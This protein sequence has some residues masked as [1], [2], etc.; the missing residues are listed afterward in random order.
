[1]LSFS[2]CALVG[3][4]TMQQ[5]E[6]DAVPR[7]LAELTPGDRISVRTAQMWDDVTVVAVDAAT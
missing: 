5:V 4:T 1:M 2:I 7:A 6:R 3:C